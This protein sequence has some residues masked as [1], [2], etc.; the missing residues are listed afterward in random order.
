[1]LRTRSLLGVGLQDPLEDV[2]A[3]QTPDRIVVDGVHAGAEGLLLQLRHPAHHQ[4][5]RHAQQQQQQQ[6][7]HRPGPG[8][9]PGWLLT[10]PRAGLGF[11]SDKVTGDKKVQSV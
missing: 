6:L 8:V 4:P 11:W 10:R 3:A 2:V 1:M 5:A 7:Q 9:L